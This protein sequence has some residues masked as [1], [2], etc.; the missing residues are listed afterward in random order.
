MPENKTKPTGRGGA[1]I[2]GPGKKL[3]PRPTGRTRF[4]AYVT[5]EE[6]EEILRAVPRLR[7]TKGSSP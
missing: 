7:E 4:V 1:R 6:R 3:G 5:E 2:P